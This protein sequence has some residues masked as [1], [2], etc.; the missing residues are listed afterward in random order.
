MVYSALTS[1]LLIHCV[2]NP[3]GQGDLKILHRE[4]H[5]VSNKWFSLGVQLQVPVETLKCIE[6]E[7]RQITKCLLE[8]LIVWLE[9]I[10]PPCSW[11]ILTE[12]LESPPLGERL[13]AQQLRDKYYQRTGEEVTHGYVQEPSLCAL[14][15]QQGSYLL[16]LMCVCV[17]VLCMCVF[18]ACVCSKGGG[19]EKNCLGGTEIFFPLTAHLPKPLDH[20]LKPYE[21]KAKPTGIELGSGTYGTVIELRSAGEIVAGKVFK[22]SLT[23]DH[24]KLCGELSL[25]AQVHHPNIVQCKGVCRL[26][27]QT[28]PVLLMERLMSSLHAYLLDPIRSNLALERKVSILHD[29]ASG[30]KYLHSNKPTIIHRDL[31]AKNVLLDSELTAKIADFGNARIMDLDPETTPETFTSLP[32][33]RDYMPPEAEGGTKYDSSLDV[34]S[35]GHLSLFT[36]IQSPV[37]PLL[38][39]TYTDDE[40]LHARSEVKRREQYLEKAEEL[41]GEEHSLVVLVKQCLHNYPAQRPQTADLVTRLQD[42]SHTLEGADCTL[43]SQPDTMSHNQPAG[44]Q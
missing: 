16:S 2:L 27:D 1:P 38:P 4:L 26:E 13:L 23:T 12:A 40:G 35:F 39:S 11:S 14:A 41:L 18:C 10:N 8:M 6:M 17:C 20:Q 36:I 22:T 24:H 21:R 29:V 34:F 43:H 7:N 28:M 31:T 19:G 3:V 37:H 42:T 32:G 15:A 33:T 5:P 25:M 30:L 44:Q 9:Q